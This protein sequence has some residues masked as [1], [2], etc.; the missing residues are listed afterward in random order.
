VNNNEQKVNNPSC[1]S[2]EWSDYRT[3]S[4][5][6]LS[7][8]R[9]SLEL[10]RARRHQ[11]VLI[12]MRMHRGVRK[13]LDSLILLVE[14]DCIEPTLRHDAWLDTNQKVLHRD[15]NLLIPF[16]REVR[17]SVISDSHIDIG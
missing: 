2:K 8:D 3:F 17:G 14:G 12:N 9:A 16:P 15:I 4:F 7:V 6:H 13:P 11:L 10:A 5:L 1:N